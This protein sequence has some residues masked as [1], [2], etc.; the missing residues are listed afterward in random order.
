MDL[1]LQRARA[2]RMLKSLGGWQG[3]G[4]SFLRTCPRVALA[5]ATTDAERDGERMYGRKANARSERGRTGS[6]ESAMFSV[7]GGKGTMTL[8]GR[9]SRVRMR[10]RIWNQTRSVIVPAV[11]WPQT[12]GYHDE[13]PYFL[14]P[15]KAAWLHALQSARQADRSP[16]PPPL[17]S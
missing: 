9:A 8:A 16:L 12:V 6:Q 3:S 14:L 10:T 11:S 15:V 1:R 7:Y 2:P 13:Q 5:A 17:Y 4:M